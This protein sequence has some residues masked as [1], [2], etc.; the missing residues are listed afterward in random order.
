MGI[1]GG[2]ADTAWKRENRVMRHVSTVLILSVVALVSLSLTILASATMLDKGADTSLR[3]QVLATIAGF[4]GL[5]MAMVIGHR[6]IGSLAWLWYVVALVLLL[7][8]WSPF[9]RV[10]NNARR[11]VFGVQPSEFA[12]LALILMIAWYAGRYPAR[13]PKFF[14]GICPPILLCIPLVG[15]IYN[16]PDRSTAILIIVT[17]G[18]MLFVSGV[19]WLHLGMMGLMAAAP[20]IALLYVSPLGMSRFDAWMNP[21]KHQDGQG[22]QLRMALFA[23]GEGGIEGQGLGRGTLKYKVSEAHTDFIL[24]VVGEELGLPATLTIV[25]AYFAILWCGFMIVRHAPD[26]HSQ[27]LASGIVFLI[28]AQ[29]T[30]NIGVVTGLLINTG[31]PLPF[32]SR[33]GSSIAVLLTAVGLLLSIEREC[34]S[35]SKAGES[36]RA[37]FNPFASEPRAAR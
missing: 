18:I 15:L 34:V 21:E 19:R 28:A 12:K 25:A 26:L 3:N 30:I 13:I 6:R 2:W 23:F 33:G 36:R 27:V 4:S 29:A 22:L 16:Q 14:T 20:I 17:A 7:M 32:I 1:N 31:M 37:S 24:P 9:G 8:V 35:R 5:T 11:W 10:A